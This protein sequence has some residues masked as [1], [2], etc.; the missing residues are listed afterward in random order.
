[1]FRRNNRH[2]F[3]MPPTINSQEMQRSNCYLCTFDPKTNFSQP[4]KFQS[5][6]TR[7]PNIRRTNMKYL[8]LG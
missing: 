6:G 8:V 3:D 1:M 2:K 7:T 5:L 4:K